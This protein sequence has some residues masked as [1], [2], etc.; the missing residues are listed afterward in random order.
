M[1]FNS[2]AAVP[3][4]QV[5]SERLVSRLFVTSFVSAGLP[6]QSVLPKEVWR[7]LN[8]VSSS[9]KTQLIPTPSAACLPRPSIDIAGLCYA[10][11][12]VSHQVTW[13]VTK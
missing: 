12:R 10:L 8:R 3:A 6:T 11:P 7:L 4:V 9:Y 1:G 13:T 2:Q 5:N